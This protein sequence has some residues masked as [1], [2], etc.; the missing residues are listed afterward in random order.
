MAMIPPQFAEPADPPA[1]GMEY[2]LIKKTGRNI[3][4]RLRA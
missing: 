2:A 1:N 3:H 4:V